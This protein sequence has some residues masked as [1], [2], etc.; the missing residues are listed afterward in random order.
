MELNEW[1]KLIDKLIKQGVLHSQN[2][3]RAM[4]TIPRTNFLPQDMKSYSSSDT[5]LPIGFGQTIS[6]PHSF[7]LPLN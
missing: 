2:V 3:I 5:P 1:N 7:S 4:R 6:A